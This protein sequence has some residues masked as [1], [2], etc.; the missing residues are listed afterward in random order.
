MTPAYCSFAPQR[1]E[2]RR[3]VVAAITASP[4]IMNDCA[5]IRWRHRPRPDRRSHEHMSKWLRPSGLR[6]LCNRRDDRGPLIPVLPAV[7]LSLIWAGAAH[8]R[9]RSNKAAS[10]AGSYNCPYLSPGHHVEGGSPALISSVAARP[11]GCACRDSPDF[12]ALEH[13]RQRDLVPMRDRIAALR[14]TGKPLQIAV[15]DAPGTRRRPPPHRL[16]D[17]ASSEPGS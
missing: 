8:N 5:L 16:P 6:P 13:W 17:A 4:S 3:A 2:V 12:G 1:M 14:G 15:D 9:L 11:D 7:P 10:L